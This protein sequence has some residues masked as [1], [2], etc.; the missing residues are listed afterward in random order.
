ME[1]KQ[2]TEIKISW[3]RGVLSLLGL[4]VSGFIVLAYFVLGNEG[5]KL[6]FIVILIFGGL[7]V[8]LSQELK[9]IKFKNKDGVSGLYKKVE[10]K[11]QKTTTAPVISDKKQ[12]EKKDIQLPKN[13]I[14]IFVLSMIVLVL[15]IVF[16]Q[17]HTKDKK[18]NEFCLEKIE[19]LNANSGYL[20]RQPNNNKKFQS[21]DKAEEYCREIVYPNR[22]SLDLKKSEIKVNFVP[23][24][25]NTYKSL[26]PIKSQ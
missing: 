2:T 20:I 21:R 8:Y 18:I 11:E 1:Q 10:I 19:Y 13:T 17:V 7:A 15:G 9:A 4:I 22:P 25:K 3:I 23:S 6:P 5:I 24:S 16:F 26:T 12:K 14:K